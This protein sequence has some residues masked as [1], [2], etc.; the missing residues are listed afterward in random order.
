VAFCRV[1]TGL[2]QHA[3]RTTSNRTFF[4]HRRCRRRSL[5]R[6]WSRTEERLPRARDV[7][8][9]DVTD[10]RAHGGNTRHAT[11]ARRRRRCYLQRLQSRF[12]RLSAADENRSDESRSAG[13]RFCV[14]LVTVFRGSAN[15]PSN[16]SALL[17]PSNMFNHVT[18][19]ILNITNIFLIKSLRLFSTFALSQ[20]MAVFNEK[21]PENVGISL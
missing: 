12:F 7:T 6:G 9:H 19:Q 15:V 1:E 20:S 17:P 4:D 10:D 14:K 16:F 5:R 3:R 13:H 8:V 2:V 21:L 18:S 11:G